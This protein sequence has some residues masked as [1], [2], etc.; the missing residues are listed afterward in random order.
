MGLFQEI[1]AK[2]LS[3]DLMEAGIETELILSIPSG[4]LARVPVT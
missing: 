4:G 2:R 3:P 1:L